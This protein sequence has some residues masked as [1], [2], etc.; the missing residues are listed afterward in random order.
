M[1]YG[2]TETIP[3]IKKL[4]MSGPIFLTKLGSDSLE[5]IL[6]PNVASLS[7]SQ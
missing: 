2:I 6:T 7:V 3:M 4:G 5:A 1:I